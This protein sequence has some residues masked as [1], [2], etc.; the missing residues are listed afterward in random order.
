MKL[1]GWIV[2]EEGHFWI[3]SETETFLKSILYKLGN[4][5]N[6]GKIE[7]CTI[8]IPPSEEEK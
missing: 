2:I 3:A 5:K 8:T 6:E 1:E 7:R 4:E